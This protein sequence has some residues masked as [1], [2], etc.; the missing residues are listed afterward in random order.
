[1]CGI[2]MCGV[3][4][5]GGHKAS[6][7]VLLLHILPFYTSNWEEYCTGV[8]RF[9]LVG[10]TE[11]QLLIVGLLAFTGYIGVDAW[12]APVDLPAWMAEWAPAV[13]KPSFQQ[14]MEAKFILVFV[15]AAGVLYQV[16]FC[17]ILSRSLARAF[18]FPRARCAP[19]FVFGCD[20]RR[21]VAGLG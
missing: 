14:P 17:S 2:F 1:M 11:G 12:N 6:S 8:M 18:F 3:L 13:L 10:I 20:G 9:G 21:G 5:L 4:G 15:G 7:I 19:R 16:R